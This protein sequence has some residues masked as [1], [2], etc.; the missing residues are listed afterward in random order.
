MAEKAKNTKRIASFA[1]EPEGSNMSKTKQ[2]VAEAAGEATEEQLDQ[3]IQAL[4]EEREEL[5]LPPALTWAQIENNIAQTT[6]SL[7]HREAR[8]RVVPHLLR[9]YRARRVRME[10]ERYEREMAPLYEAQEAAHDKQEELREQVRELE[11]RAGMAQ[12]EWHSIHL[13][14]G[15]RERHMKELSSQLQELEGDTDG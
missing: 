3:T 14:I 6:Q 4:E 12:G 9:A 7:E 5:E 1:S 10:L 15:T 8:K 13:K 11:Y 2:A